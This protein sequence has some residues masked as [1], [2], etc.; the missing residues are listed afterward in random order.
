MSRTARPAINRPFRPRPPGSAEAG[1]RLACAIGGRTA[2]RLRDFDFEAWTALL[3]E[4]RRII[5]SA[6][7]VDPSRVKI[8]LGH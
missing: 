7:G 3:E 4:Q 2:R 6:A 8:R 1:P 5:A